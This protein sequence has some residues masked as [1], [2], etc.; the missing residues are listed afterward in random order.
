MAGL[1]SNANLGSS[2]SSIF[3]GIGDLAE[4]GDYN[5]AAKIAQTNAGIAEESGKIQE[6][7]AQRQITQKIGAQQSEVAGAGLKESGSAISL[8]KNSMAQGALSK[9]LIAAQTA[10]NVGGFEQEAAA[11]K[12]MA[13]AATA[14]GIGN[15]AGGILGIFGL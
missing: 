6:M 1:F 9:Q 3:G 12:G 4:A 2:V 7:Q 8:Y 10:I 5:K 11:Y 15:I 14:S 13:G